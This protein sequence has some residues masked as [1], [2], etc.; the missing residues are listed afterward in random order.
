MR[1]RVHG[2]KLT[3]TASHRLALRRNLCQSLFEH[4]EVR[5]TVVKAKE[6][7][8]LAER[9]ISLAVD[10]SLPAR[11]RAEALLQDR[12]VIPSEHQEDYDKMSD[13]KRDKTLRAR[14]GRHYRT[15]TTRPGLKFTAESVLGKLFKDIG[16]RM[17]ARNEKLSSS[18]GYTRIIKLSDRRLG[19]GGQLA[20]LQLVSDD[21]KPRTKNKDKTERKRRARVKYT[22]YAGKPRP[23]GRRRAAKAGAKAEAAAPLPPEAAPPAESPA[24]SADGAEAEK[25]E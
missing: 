12:A 17:K 5:T 20:I 11:Q 25:T 22:V 1:H 16:P 6:F 18:G 15:N 2:R 9:L 19:D 10:G 24:E 13:A 21:D 3:R 7:R 8:P 14:S 4:G 23:V